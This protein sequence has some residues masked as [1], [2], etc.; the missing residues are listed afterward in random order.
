MCPSLSWLEVYKTL[1]HHPTSSWPVE[2]P[3]SLA[4]QPLTNSGSISGTARHHVYRHP[5][6][7]PASFRKKKKKKKKEPFNLKVAFHRFPGA[8]AYKGV[9]RAILRA[10]G[11][12]ATED[13][14]DT[15]R[16][17]VVSE[18]LGDRL[19]EGGARLAQLPDSSVLIAFVRGPDH[20]SQLS[21]LP[22]AFWF[23]ETTTTVSLTPLGAVPVPPAR[24]TSEPQLQGG[25]GGDTVVAA[26]ADAM[27]VTHDAA[28][29]SETPGVLAAALAGVQ[30]QLAAQQ[31]QLDAQHQL[32]KGLAACL[33]T[34]WAPLDPPA[35]APVDRGHGPV[36]AGVAPTRAPFVPEPRPT[37]SAEL[38]EPGPA[39]PTPTPTP[40]AAPGHTLQPP[41]P[42][43]PPAPAS[44]ADLAAS[45][46]RSPASGAPVAPPATHAAPPSME[47]AAGCDAHAPMGQ[48]TELDSA[49]ASVAADR[50]ALSSPTPR[51][52]VGHPNRSGPA[53]DS[54]RA[55]PAE[56]ARQ[57][58]WRQPGASWGRVEGRTQ[59]P[60]S[61]AAGRQL[62]PLRKITV[63]AGLPNSRGSPPQESP[64][65]AAANRPVYASSSSP[66]LL[67]P[68][69]PLPAAQAPTE[70]ARLGLAGADTGAGGSMQ[71]AASGMGPP[72]WLVPQACLPKP[73][74]LG[75]LQLR[76]LQESEE[77][78]RK[79]R[80]LP[81]HPAQ[82]RPGL[83]RL[84]AG[85]KD[86]LED[87]L[88]QPVAAAE[89][90][91][92][93]VESASRWP[94]AHPLLSPGAP[95]HVLLSMFGLYTADLPSPEDVD[96][97]PVARMFVQAVMQQYDTFKDPSPRRPG[98]KRPAPSAQE[99]DPATPLTPAAPAATRRRQAPVAQ[100]EPEHGGAPT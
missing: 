19:G 13:P 3:R 49:L 39:G 16:P 89:V 28:A 52:G 66:P 79:G 27:E 85:Y 98:I 7:S 25:V 40:M 51:A 72:P 48:L 70:A 84:T 15:S 34:H 63:A 10:A 62:Q 8:L 76:R 55:A 50:Q 69:R 65:A 14:A 96:P 95:R 46:R 26:G 43:A 80:Q 20:D 56:G 9:T 81:P 86:A 73:P 22:H 33:R 82:D 93:A 71:P 92:R 67:E 87:V 100:Q 41:S 47:A 61:A 29:P 1:T 60:V 58:W 91:G 17:L 94:A 74:L 32:L 59:Q 42:A 23:S 35:P 30:A 4:C 90:N 12:D 64:P 11:Y 5:V 36:P 45:W 24:P 78:D 31:A 97:L 21:Q 6:P 68:Q 57:H 54:P 18:F 75:E 99:E 37:G 2:T 88:H 53:L 38:A 44:R 77:A 83:Q